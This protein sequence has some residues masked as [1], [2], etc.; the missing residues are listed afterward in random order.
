MGPAIL[1]ALFLALAILLIWWNYQR[2]KQRRLALASFAARSGLQF[3]VDDPFDLLR[4]DFRLLHMGAG[5]GCE[6][7]VS[8]DWHGMPAREADYWYYTESTDSNGNKSRS[9]KYF[10]VLEAELAC[11]VPAVSI[12]RETLMSRL[13]DHVGFADLEFESERFNRD[14]Q[15]R[16]GDR[17][18]AYR[19]VDARMMEWL[20]DSTDG[21]GFEISGSKMLAWCGRRKPEELSGV[22]DTALGFRDHIPRLVW[23]EYGTSTAD[24]LEGNERRSS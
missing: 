18:F 6:N 17:E 14:F 3:A 10:S 19:L 21:F 8:G 5:R 1:F 4:D 9:Y 23:N 16:S 15:V 11:T 22:F 13:A 7:V 24:A 2:K 12:Q 20:M